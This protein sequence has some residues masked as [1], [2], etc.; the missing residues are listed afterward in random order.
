MYLGHE[1]NQMQRLNNKLYLLM[2]FR[3]LAIVDIE[4]KT[5][6]LKVEFSD[7][8]IT[9]I[10]ATQDQF[11]FGDTFSHLYMVKVSDLHKDDPK[12]ANLKKN[13]FLGHEGWILAMGIINKYLLTCSDD[14][15]IKVWEL[16]GGRILIY[17]SHSER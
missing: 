7:H 3:E 1:I 6:D 11:F 16:P 8:T 12:G 4:S 15:S 10:F 2:N 14:K 5:V 17:S 13:R 9:C